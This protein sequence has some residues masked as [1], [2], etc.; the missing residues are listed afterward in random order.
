MAR[1][2]ARPAGDVAKHLFRPIFSLAERD[3]IRTHGSGGSGHVRP[4]ASCQKSSIWRGFMS[5]KVPCGPAVPFRS[6]MK[7]ILGKQ[8]GL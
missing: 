8:L 5:S 7:E 6:I 2:N 4:S 3:T 1:N